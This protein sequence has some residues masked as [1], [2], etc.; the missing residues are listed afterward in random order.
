VRSRIIAAP[1]ITSRG[2]T[3]QHHRGAQSHSAQDVEN[4]RAATTDEAALKLMYLAIKNAKKTWG[5]S[6]RDWLTAG[7]QLNIRFEG[8]L[9]TT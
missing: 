3:H 8:R 7:S 2:N 1:L 5:R 6:H 4:A 9:P